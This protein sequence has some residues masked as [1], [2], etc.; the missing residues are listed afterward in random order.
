MTGY[1]RNL[2]TQFM[3]TNITPTSKEI[4]ETI[5]CRYEMRVNTEQA[6][7]FKLGNKTCLTQNTCTNCGRSTHNANQ[8]W[9]EGGGVA[10]KVPEWFKRDKRSEM[11]KEGQINHNKTN[12]KANV[13]RTEV[14][15]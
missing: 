9:S 2:L 1:A 3:N 12:S 10:D 8:C 7:V 4:I 5:S 11:V 6:N 15:Q 13:A 14:T